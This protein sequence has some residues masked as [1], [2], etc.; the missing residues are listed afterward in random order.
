[1]TVLAVLDTTVIVAGVLASHP[2]HAPCRQ[3]LQAAAATPG[4]Y[5]CSTHAIAEAFRVL[6]ALPLAPRIDAA[7]ARLVLR[8]TIIPRLDPIAL[9]MKDYDAALDL[10][11]AS[12]LGSG[13]VYDALHLLAAD[14]AGAKWLVTA[15]GKHFNRLAEVAKSRVR[16]VDPA[17]S[18]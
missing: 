11:C 7:G 17:A 1:V 14:R 2:H 4:T 10:V 13:A 16:V 5:R 9:T 12:G 6:V 18:N 8:T 3:H 15:N